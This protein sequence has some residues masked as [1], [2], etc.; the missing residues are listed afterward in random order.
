MDEKELYHHGIL[1]QKWGKRNY[2]NP[3]GTYTEEGKR[4]RRVSF[5]EIMSSPR[6][7]RAFE[8]TVKRGK[9]KPNETPAGMIAKST[10]DIAEHLARVVDRGKKNNK[11]LSGYSD[12]DLQTM[13]NRM[14]LEQQY[15]D[16]DYSTISSG[17]TKLVNVLDTIGDISAIGVSAAMILTMIQQ[18]KGK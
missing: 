3:D 5:R 14:R 17:R 11:D 7:Q 1:G 16:L 13:V 9:D 2:Q 12:K 6:A 15:R 8:P 18:I 10:G 4:R